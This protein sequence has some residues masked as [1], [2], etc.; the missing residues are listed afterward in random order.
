M[1]RRL[2]L[3]FSALGLIGL[4][5]WYDSQPPQPTRVERIVACFE[6]LRY[7]TSV[8]YDDGREPFDY[9]EGTIVLD[10]GTWQARP[11]SNQVNVGIP[12]G[13]TA[14][15]NV[16]DDGGRSHMVDDGSPLKAGERTAVAGCAQ[17]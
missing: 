1:L 8:Y 13:H 9:P 5:V 15:I 3:V 6:K 17:A 14:V 16:P 4:A 11:P 2:L 7:S 12:N 10:D